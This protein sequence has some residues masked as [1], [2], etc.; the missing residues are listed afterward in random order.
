MS[1]VER[2]KSLDIGLF[3]HVEAQSSTD[4]RRSLLALQDAL[5]ERIGTFVWLEI[6]SF[7]GGTLQPLVMDPRCEKVISIDPRPQVV[8]DDKWGE[9]TY[10]PENTTEGMLA[11]LARIP[12]ADTSKIEPIE[13]GTADIP[14]ESLDRP[15]FCFIDGEHTRAAV[16]QDARFCHNL[17]QDDGVIAFHDFQ[18][19]EPAVGDFLRELKARYMAYLLSTSVF[20]VEIGNGTPL[21]SAPLVRAQVRR[22]EYVWKLT[23]R[24]RLTPRLFDSHR[25]LRGRS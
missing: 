6:G 4:D 10:G 23:S 2:I 19:V 5:A 11:G 1:A 24:L 14:I 17:L 22:P 16:L 25:R 18:V 20:V 9:W 13:R 7:R 3:D 15:D 8:R 21:L 12:G